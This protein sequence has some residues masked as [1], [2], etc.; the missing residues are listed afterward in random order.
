MIRK[1]LTIGLLIFLIVSCGKETIGH[2][3]IENRTK[4]TVDSLRI[5]PN[6]Y[7]SDF[8]ISISPGEI[9]KYDCKMTDIVDADGDYRLDYKFYTSL[10]ATKIFGY[11]INGYPIESLI[12]IS[13]EK[14]TIII[15]S[16][17]KNN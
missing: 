15:D 8:Y 17:L 11:Y 2:F 4:N 7:E 6:G 16:E 12:K 14:D 9:K 13:I 3:E 1:L 10:F 5:I